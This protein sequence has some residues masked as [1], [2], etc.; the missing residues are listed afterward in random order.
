MLG[1]AAMD[2]RADELVPCP[3]KFLLF[4]GKKG[5][6]VFLLSGAASGGR[7]LVDATLAP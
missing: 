1:E 3:D 7:R 5:S 6:R 2:A 4:Y